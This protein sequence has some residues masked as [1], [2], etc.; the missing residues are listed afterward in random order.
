M[1]SPSAPTSFLTGQATDARSG[2][3][4]SVLQSALDSEEATTA[5]TGADD[6]TL[7][8]QEQDA[9]PVTPLSPVA[10]NLRPVETASAAESLLVTA[11]SANIE[12]G[13]MRAFPDRLTAPS[14]A[15]APA[16]TGTATAAPD[17]ELPES[18]DGFAVPL[19]PA[20]VTAS[21]VETAV[22][23]AATP[24]LHN[25]QPVGARNLTDPSAAVST[26]T[27]SGAGVD[28]AQATPQPTAG[29]TATPQSATLPTPAPIVYGTTATSLRTQTEGATVPNESS[30]PVAN[31]APA[32]SS[33]TQLESTTES[34]ESPLPAANNALAPVPHRTNT[35]SSGSR[36]ALASAAA[37]LGAPASVTV[38]AN[39][40]SVEADTDSSPSTPGGAPALTAALIP[41]TSTPSTPAAPAPAAPPPPAHGA[42]PTLNA[43]LAQ[44]LFTLA[45]ARAGEHIMTV[46]V[47]PD[48]LGP[49]TVR[50]VISSDDIRI[51]LFS[52]SDSGRDALRH[53][54][55]E[56][57]RDLST[58]GLS[59]TLDLGTKD[60]TDSKEQRAPQHEQL[61]RQF[62]EPAPTPTQGLRPNHSATSA[63]DI[64]V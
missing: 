54:L 25:I 53:I 29:R 22:V 18:A 12:N 37:P 9:A 61:P 31:G 27:V 19:V 24:T 55:P 14:S 49:V 30:L 11:P 63:L 10:T 28:L 47:N 35:E 4:A 1:V 39:F 57:R 5:A 48:T 3:F 13:D 41:V 51:E 46:Q 52:T 38:P 44:P 26:P 17:L 23:P 2:A 20:L 43:Q 40:P 7:G 33:P 62:A 36:S 16:E 8:R 45:G 42:P 15:L 34:G 60:G 56:L 50:A 32:P 64:T 58:G 59:A 6:Q 21:T